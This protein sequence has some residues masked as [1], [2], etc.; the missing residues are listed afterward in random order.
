MA[1]LLQDCNIG[2]N[3]QK[4]RVSRGMTQTDLAA[5]LDEYG[6]EMSISTLSQIENG[7]RNIFVSDLIRIKMVLDV[8]F[9]EFFAGLN[10]GG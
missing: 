1:K 3:I 10:P 4:L 7:K 8:S 5:A 9:D 2:G 6:R